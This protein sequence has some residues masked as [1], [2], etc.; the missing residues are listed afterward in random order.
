M[1]SFKEVATEFEALTQQL[2]SRLEEWDAKLTPVNDESELDRHLTTLLTEVREQHD[3]MEALVKGDGLD[4]AQIHALK[5]VYR[6]HT[7][8]FW[9]RTGIVNRNI[10]KPRGYHGDYQTMLYAYEDRYTGTT[11]LGKCL[12]RYVTTDRSAFAVRGRRRHLA[13]R[14]QAVCAR[15]PGTIFSVACGPAMEVADALRAGAAI[16][17]VVLLDQDQEALQCAERNVRPVLPGNTELALMNIGV[18]DLITSGEPEL[19]R[20]GPYDL[21][22]SAGLYDY[23]PDQAALMLNWY[24]TGLLAEDGLLEVGNFTE[25]PM[26]F[27]TDLVCG[28]RLILRGEKDLRQTA[29]EGVSCEFTRV[30]D[31]TF[32]AMGPRGLPAMREAERPPA[33]A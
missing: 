32:V 12:H 26:G 2:R 3:R 30:G 9:T 24:L 8:E 5:E 21:I 25:F 31:Q 17:R 10:T 23:L 28:M 13:A 33:F 22:Y 18:A 27:F 14:I 7:H 1:A 29:P 19:E 16:R 20:L 11:N 6:R 15:R 4:K